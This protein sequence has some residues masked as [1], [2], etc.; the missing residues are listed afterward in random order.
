VKTTQIR[1]AA[2]PVGA[3]KNSDF[4]TA[5]VELPELATVR[6]CSACCTCPSTPT[7]AAG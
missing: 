7:C 3:P 1:L 5:V 2:R 6:S 4:A